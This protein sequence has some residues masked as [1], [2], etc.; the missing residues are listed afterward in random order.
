MVGESVDQPGHRDPKRLIAGLVGALAGLMLTGA[1]VSSCFTN[2]PYRR[3]DDD[4]SVYYTTFYEEPKHFDPARSYAADAY[5]IIQQIYEPPLQYHY[6]KVPYALAPLTVERVPEPRYLDAEGR[7][8]PDDAPQDAVARAVYELKIKPGVRYEPHPCFARAEDGSY[9]WHLGA[10][11][12]F[13]AVEHPLDLEVTGTRELRA[14]DYAYQIKRMANPLLQCP[15]FPVLARYIDGFEKLA[16]RIGAEI[17]LI[18]ADRQRKAGALYNRERDEAENPIWID[19][20]KYDFPGVEVVD[21]KTLRIVLKRKYPQFKFWLAMP[22]FA[23]VPWEADRFFVQP[24]AAER[25]LTLDRFPVGTGPYALTFAQSNWRMVLS[26]N[27]NYVDR[28]TYPA[29][30]MPEDGPAGLLEDAG[31]PLPFIDEVVYV[32]EKESMPR[33]QKFL[34]GYYDSSGIGGDVF[35]QAVD[36]TMEGPELTD[37]LVEKDIRLVTSPSPTVFYYAFNMLDDVVG[38]LDEK[39]RKLRRAI[40]IA[41]DFEELIQIFLNDRA[42]PGMGPIPPQ[43]AGHTS[44]REGLNPHVYD[45]D[46]AAGTARRKSLEEARRLLAEA[47]YPGGVGE[48]GRPLVLYFDT[49]AGGAGD[50]A[51]MDW[52]RKQFAKLNIQLQVRST[53]YSQFQDKTRKGNWQ[54]LR[55]G[56]HADYPDPENFLFLLYG[57]NGKVR[58]Q[59]ENAANYQNPR[60]DELFEK[61]ENME[62]SPEREA[63]IREMLEIARADAPWMWGYYPVSFGLYH[64][65]LGNVKPMS[66]SYNTKKY[67][68]I[69]VDLRN[70]RRAEW[71][72]PVTWPIWLLLLGIYAAIV[73]GAIAV[74]RRQTRG[75][76]A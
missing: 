40:S 23:P 36:V 60:Y 58:A 65:W 19:L 22:F 66:I 20:R 69:D 29:K 50:K 16:S 4:R 5:Q 55:W 13:P 11:G 8:L 28:E 21:D 76:G 71:N 48:D 57:P 1:L 73:P 35:D 41:F 42:I 62:D 47:G 25:N 15:I 26:R 46:E 37:F 2:R 30:G 43:I 39:K 7:P 59:G 72:E 53:D 67:H 14:E 74:W 27:P 9:R 64:E 12:E 49:T 6:L 45:W 18:R 51:F 68:R 54:I 33:W 10:G 3:G 38:G 56:W 75:G 44:G 70:R 32:L 17:E 61:M 52:L 34:Q 31:S 24:A 63:I